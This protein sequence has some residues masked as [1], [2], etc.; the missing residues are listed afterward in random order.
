MRFPKVKKVKKHSSQQPR[1][2]KK[3]AS[4]PPI[5][6]G[7]AALPGF[8][9]SIPLDPLLV[10]A[11]VGAPTA[12]H[13]DYAKTLLTSLPHELRQATHDMFSARAVVFALLL[14]TDDSIRRAQIALIEA[15]EGKPTAKETSRLFDLVQAQ[16]TEYRLPLIQMVQTS[17]LSM[18]LPQYEQFRNT[19]NCIVKADKQLGMFEFVV[20]RSLILQLDRHFEKRRPPKVNYFA[21]QAIAKQAGELLSILVHTG[22]QDG[23]EAQTAFVQALSP[24]KLQP[25]VPLTPR[26]ECSLSL[27]KD[28]LDVLVKSSPVIKKRLLGAAVVAVTT[29]GNVTVSEAELLRAIADSLDCPLPPIVP[30]I[31]SK[32]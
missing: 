19:V 28:S 3:S 9:N 17:L 29:D 21:V 20:Q 16:P 23:Q 13:M 12:Q 14:D 7:A 22:H 11:A 5:L 18:T 10:V 15:S 25:T 6:P 27:L 24:L 32:K 31:T 30:G 2:S 1:K 4:I 8:P 26:T